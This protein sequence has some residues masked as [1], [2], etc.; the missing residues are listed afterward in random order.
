MFM[1]SWNSEPPSGTTS[2]LRLRAR[3]Q[4]LLRCSR[5]GWL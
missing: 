5:R 4:D 1:L 2:M 3:L